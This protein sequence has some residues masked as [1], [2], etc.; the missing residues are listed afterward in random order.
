MQLNQD[1]ITLSS[2]FGNRFCNETRIVCAVSF[3]RVDVAD[4]LKLAT[5]TLG[6]GRIP[7]CVLQKSLWD[8]IL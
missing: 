5:S 4:L 7:E 1:T 3:P 8:Y 2:N 6:N